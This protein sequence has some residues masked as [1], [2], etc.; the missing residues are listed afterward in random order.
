MLG[1]YELL[2]RGKVGA[3]KA[4]PANGTICYRLISSPEDKRAKLTDRTSI[5]PIVLCLIE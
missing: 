3:R 1:S 4:L 5:R 2:I